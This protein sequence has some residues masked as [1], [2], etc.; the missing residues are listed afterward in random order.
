MFDAIGLVSDGRLF[1]SLAELQRDIHPAHHYVNEH[2]KPG[3]CALMVGEA[4]VWDI[5]VPVR[6]NTCFDDCN[7]EL[8]LKLKP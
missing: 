7:L 8:L 4:Q 6:Y 5:A 3:H 1:V 2:V